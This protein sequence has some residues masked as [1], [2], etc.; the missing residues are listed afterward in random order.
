[1]SFN[2]TFTANFSDSDNE[3]YEAKLARRRAKTEA[4]LQEQEE[5]E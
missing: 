2:N 3:H 5:K 4:L 1:M